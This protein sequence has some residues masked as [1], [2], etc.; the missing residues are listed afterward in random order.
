MFILLSV[1]YKLLDD[2]ESSFVKRI[3]LSSFSSDR[4]FPKLIKPISPYPFTN[5]PLRN[6]IKNFFINH[7]YDDIINHKDID[8]NTYDYSDSD[9]KE[10]IE[11]I[12][13]AFCFKTSHKDICDYIHK[14]FNYYGIRIAESHV[15]LNSFYSVR[16]VLD[17]NAVNYKIEH[18][19][20]KYI[21]SVRFKIFE[22]KIKKLFL[23]WR[24]K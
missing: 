20:P 6:K 13:S 2:N 16:L 10:V 8:L 11:E 4:V 7:C 15:Q 9:D 21:R 12:C 14:L 22:H 24:Y 1:F 19:N 3:S 18:L 5:A 23:F 17:Y